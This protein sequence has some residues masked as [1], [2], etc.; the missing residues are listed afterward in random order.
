MM[1]KKKAAETNREKEKTAH[2]NK[3]W[4]ELRRGEKMTAAPKCD[5]D[6]KRA[7]KAL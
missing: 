1:D 6:V 5:F 3:T 4:S 7:G 2:H